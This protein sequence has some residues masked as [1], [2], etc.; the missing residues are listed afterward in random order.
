MGIISILV[1]FSVSYYFACNEETAVPKITRESNTSMKTMN[2]YVDVIYYIN[3]DHRPDRK[4]EIL[5]ELEKYGISP[6]KIVRIPAVYLKE[7]GH[8]GCSK[9]HI[10]TVESFLKSEYKNCVILED[11][12]QFV[13]PPNK[14]NGAFCDLFESNLDFDVCMLAGNIYTT[15]YVEEYPFVRK[16][17]QIL[18]TAGYM[19]SR[20]FAQTLLENFKEGAEKLEK[21]YDEKEGKTELGQYA[22]DGQYAID[23]YWTR[24]QGDKSKWYIFEPKMA[25]QR[26]SY[27]D[28]MAGNVAYNV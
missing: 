13:E 17:V 7:R 5:E 9:S 6:E 20:N 26:D 8:L 12:F 10:L 22:Y 15:D 23:Q 11:D 27:S 3:L 16:A 19:V 1:I 14:V 28:I 4:T 21:S 25:K 18:T 24:L 2:D